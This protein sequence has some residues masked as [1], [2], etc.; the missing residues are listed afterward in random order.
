MIG[1]SF[2]RGTHAVILVVHNHADEGLDAREADAAQFCRELESVGGELARLSICCDC[3]CNA[4]VPLCRCYHRVQPGLLR[5]MCRSCQCDLEEA[6][7]DDEAMRHE[8][9][10]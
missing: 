4:A 6:A 10:C 2:L 1:K 3:D 7:G 8:Q 9:A 5:F